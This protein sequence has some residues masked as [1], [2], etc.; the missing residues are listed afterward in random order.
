MNSQ[1]IAII[2]DIHIE[3]NSMLELE[4]IFSEII[5]KVE[6]YDCYF[7]GD[8]FHKHKPTPKEI[9]FALTWFKKI[10]QSGVKCLAIPGNHDWH[11]GFLTTTILQHSTVWLGSE[12][13]HDLHLNLGLKAYLGHFF[14]KESWDNYTNIENSIKSVKNN[15][16]DYVFL[17]HQ[18]RFQELDQNAYH[19]GS[20][21]YVG[22]GEYTNPII[23][24]K[25][26]IINSKNDVNFIDLKTPHTL[27]QFNNVKELL[28]YYPNRTESIFDK[29]RIVYN[30]FNTYK[31]DINILNKLPLVLYHPLKIKLDFKNNHIVKNFN[32][33]INTKQIK[34]D[35]VVKKW[36]DTIKDNDVKIILEEETKILCD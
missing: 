17:G 4:A 34:I 28:D 8:I 27:K 25:I 15:G 7:L 33:S 13:G 26:A 35:E 30:D 20:I 3:E 9:E 22:Y 2:G 36:L 1:K 11:S 10:T 18:H 23:P 32:T 12:F 19:L 14:V 5:S 21:R 6:G 29:I 16:A 24:K 31:N